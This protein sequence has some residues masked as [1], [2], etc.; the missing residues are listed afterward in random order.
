ML[1]RC[2]LWA[3]KNRLLINVNK[4]KVMVV[5]ENPTIRAARRR[6]TFTL[7]P[8][9]PTPLEPKAS[10]ITK[11]AKR[12]QRHA[13]QNPVVWVEVPPQTSGEVVSTD[14]SGSSVINFPTVGMVCPAL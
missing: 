14:L 9:F 6:F 13:T 1:D 3:E 10:V 5:Y 8:T 4:T 7:S 2:Q 12:Y 11:I